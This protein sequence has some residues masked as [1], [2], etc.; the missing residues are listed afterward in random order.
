M[1]FFR[2]V[3]QGYEG[4]W[5]VNILD[6][7]MIPINL[8]GQTLTAQ[9]QYYM[10]NTNASGPVQGSFVPILK[11]DGTPRDPFEMA[12]AIDSDQVN[13]PGRTILQIPAN[14]YT[15]E[16]PLDA[17]IIPCAIIV[18]EYGFSGNTRPFRGGI[19]FRRGRV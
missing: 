19:L 14:L 1:S 10:V 7:D 2:E 18:V 4:P 11:S 13:N 15:D 17:T 5:T 3:I 16:I 6:K 8:T 9:A 12:I